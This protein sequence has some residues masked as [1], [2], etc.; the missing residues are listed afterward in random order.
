[1]NTNNDQ[2]HRRILVIDDNRAIHEDFKKIFGVPDDSEAALNEAESAMFDEPSAQNNRLE[3]AIDSAFQGQ[4]GLARVQ[5]AKK[6]NRPYS[7]VFVDGRMP[8][9]WDGIETTVRIWEVDP[10]VQIIICTAYSDYSWDEMVAKLPKSDQLLIL[11]KPFDIIEVL[12]MASALTE[13][14]RLHQAVKFK[15]EHLQLNVDARTRVL[16]IEISKLKAENALLRGS[17]K[18]QTKVAH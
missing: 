14:W 11:K 10:E 3:F 1:M 12:Q 4:E 17:D 15:L 7:L 5:Q 6:E 8:P 9:G 2:P 13:K 16:E 18:D